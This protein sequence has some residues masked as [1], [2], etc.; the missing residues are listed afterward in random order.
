[1]NCKLKYFLVVLATL[2][3]TT[4]AWGN[5]KV[6]VSGRSARV[7]EDKLHLY[8]LNGN[9]GEI[10]RDSALLTA[11]ET[12]RNGMVPYMARYAK[13]VL[14]NSAEIRRKP[15]AK[16]LLG[17]FFETRYYHYL[18]PMIYDEDRATL[19]SFAR[20]ARFR[21]EEVIAAFLVPDTMHMLAKDALS[22]NILPLFQSQKRPDTWGNVPAVPVRPFGC[23]SF[24]I[25]GH[26]TASRQMV[27]GRVLD[28]PG[29]GILDKNPAVYLYERPGALRYMAVLSA[30]L[31]AAVSSMNERGLTLALHSIISHD[32]GRNGFPIMSITRK[33]MEEASTIEQAAAICNANVPT[34]PWLL[35]MADTARPGG[36]A[37]RIEINP[38]L[39]KCQVIWEQDYSMALNHF[40]D[41]VNHANEYRFTPATDLH[42]LGRERRAR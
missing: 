13:T 30:G 12:L 33:I 1:M 14:F 16:L 26:R 4:P 40:K 18:Q 5:E 29:V 10:G 42:E 22:N 20:F 6:Y 7:T 25:P 37:A 32:A 3:S 11:P 2:I 28:Y 38:R 24:V 34:T 36:R 8:R 9:S 27:F 31:G 41:P 15:V 35:N 21:E 39:N 23:T 19:R 17:R